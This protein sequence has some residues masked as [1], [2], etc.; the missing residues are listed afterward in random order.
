MAGANGGSR[1]LPMLYVYVLFLIVDGKACQ[2]CFI[3]EWDRSVKSSFSQGLIWAFSFQVWTIF[4]VFPILGIYYYIFILLHLVALPI[5]SAV[6]KNEIKLRM[7]PQPHSNGR[8]WKLR[9]VLFSPFTPCCC[10]NKQL[11]L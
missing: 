8:S 3:Q 5:L 7:Q 1:P 4:M 9:Q 6:S 11:L 10:L 2:S